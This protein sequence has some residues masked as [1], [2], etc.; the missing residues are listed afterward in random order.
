MDTEKQSYGR[1]RD[2]IAKTVQQGGMI[3]KQEL[4]KLYQVSW[5]TIRNWIYRHQ[6]LAIYSDSLLSQK[7]LLTPAQYRHIFE[8][9]G[10]PFENDI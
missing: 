1:T 3:Q 8:K 9:L 7:N 2:Q 4:A 6:D 10:E 5:E